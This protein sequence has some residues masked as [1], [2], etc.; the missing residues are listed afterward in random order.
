MSLCNFIKIYPK[1]HFDALGEI[2]EAE[3]NR[4]TFKDIDASEFK[5]LLFIWIQIF[6]HLRPSLWNI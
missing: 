4:I 1:N 5:M 2:P 3:G 6:I